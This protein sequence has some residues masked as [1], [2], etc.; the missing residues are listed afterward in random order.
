MWHMKHIND[1][2][3]LMTTPSCVHHAVAHQ[4]INNV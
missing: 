1:Y 3:N 4:F 2:E